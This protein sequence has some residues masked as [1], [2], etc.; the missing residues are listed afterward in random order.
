QDA[1]KRLHTDSTTSFATTAQL[2]ILAP[3][4]VWNFLAD[5]ATRW[6]N[7]CAVRQ[8]DGND[9]LTYQ[10]VAVR[11]LAIA[12]HLRARGVQPGDRV[13]CLMLNGVD[14][15]LSYFAVAAAGAIFVS[16]NTRLTA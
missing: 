14:H 15:M 9:D 13:G 11:A 7:R 4:N 1:W 3:V 10:N 5:A 6:P 12:G 2:D 8:G 16:L